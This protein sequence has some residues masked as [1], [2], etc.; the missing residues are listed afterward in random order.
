M[1]QN[2]TPEQIAEITKVVEAQLRATGQNVSA[3][4]LLPDLIAILNQL[5]TFITSLITGPGGA[6][7]TLLTTLV[8][9]LLGA[10]TGITGTLAGSNIAP[11]LVNIIKEQL[12]QQPPK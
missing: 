4:Q 7:V 1:A 10:L 3:Q 5:P 6:A 11:Q 8:N 2:L 12:P 9:S